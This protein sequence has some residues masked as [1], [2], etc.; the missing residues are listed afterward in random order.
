M[1]P[2]LDMSKQKQR[3]L[4]LELLGSSSHK[5]PENIVECEKTFQEPH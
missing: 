2:H 4:L 5:K 3:Y 1:F